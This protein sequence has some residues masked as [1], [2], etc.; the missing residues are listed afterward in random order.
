MQVRAVIDEAVSMLRASLRPGVE[1]IVED[2]PAEITILGDPVQLQQIILNL[3]AN[4]AQAIQGN[5]AIRVTAAEKEIA[6]PMS[7]S[8][9]ELQPGRY[10]RLAVSD[11]GCGF[12]E[13]TA[14]R[15]FEPFFTTRSTGTGLGLAT[16]SEIVRDHD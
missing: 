9:G 3:C 16:V 4:A 12:G 1:L 8:H 5:G 15:L 14:L 6:G 10:A 7:L 13:V 11:T 2:I